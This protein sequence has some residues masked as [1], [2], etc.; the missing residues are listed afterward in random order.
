MTE[1]PYRARRAAGGAPPP[2]SPR[3]EAPKKEGARRRGWKIA[4]IIMASLAV[5]VII[6]VVVA[7]SYLRSLQTTFDD[8]R[9]TIEGLDLED[10]S[11]YRTPEGTVNMLLMGTDSRGDD[12]QDYR[13][14]TGEGAERSDTMMFVHIPA[15]RSGVYVM[16]IMRDLW[17]EVPGEGMGRVNTALGLGGYELAVDL[18]E[19]MLYTHIDH[20]AVVDFEGFSDLTEAL[21]GVYIDNPHSFSAGQRNPAFYPE[22][23]IRLEGSSALRYVRERQSFPTG[24]YIRVENQQR[25]VRAIL[26][27]FLSAETLSNPQRIYSVV[28]GMTPYLSVDEGLNAE[29]VAGYALDMRDVRSDDI[30]MFTMPAGEHATT[31]AGAEVILP[32]DEMMSLLRTSLAQENMGG[33]MDYIELVEQHEN[34]EFGVPDEAEEDDLDEEEDEDPD[35]AGDSSASGR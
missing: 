14:A 24:D 7:F 10:D 27:R 8:N 18:V 6:A 35:D 3:T 4:G 30:H 31:S 22:G 19:E 25:V 11:A 29:T 13:D 12:E 21:G 32:D 2:A 34:G 16:S 15:D 5:L 17:V 23:T 1:E 26:E 9:E 28:D 33:F 20:V